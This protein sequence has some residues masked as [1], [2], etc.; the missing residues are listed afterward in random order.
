MN[1]QSPGIK[2]SCNWSYHEFRERF[3]ENLRACQWEPHPLY[4]VFTQYDREHYLQRKDE[5]L[6][7]YRC[8]YA[9]SRTI[10]PAKI[11]ELGVCAGSGADAYLSASPQA[12]YTGIDTFGEPFSPDDDS[13]WRVLRKD[14]S[15]LWKPLD[16]ARQLLKDRR[17]R[18]YRLITANLR[19]LQR[20]PHAADL[21][22]VDAAHDFTN[23]YPDLQL[24]LTADPTFIFVDD[25]EDASQAKPAIEKFLKEDLLDR[26]DYTLAIDY[27]G[28]GLLIKLKK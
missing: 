18:R 26:V 23:E 22:V 27:L 17:F 28:G 21:V 9:V 11:I 19:H 25:S 5:F 15:S 8:F 2:D 14:E 6:H 12:E 10:S 3:S 1:G 4:S 24:A 13:P 20:L 16:I 7:K